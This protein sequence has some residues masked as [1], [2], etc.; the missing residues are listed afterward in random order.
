M[1]LRL[2]LACT[3]GRLQTHSY[4][5]KKNVLKLYGTNKV[6]TKRTNKV[7]ISVS[8]RSIVHYDTALQYNDDVNTHK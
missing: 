5:F 1:M 3:T 7:R 4:Y 8:L 2:S 6:K